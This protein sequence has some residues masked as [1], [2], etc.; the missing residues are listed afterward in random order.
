MTVMPYLQTNKFVGLKRDA[1][2]ANEYLQLYSQEI[3][4]SI[5]NK[6]EPP[7]DTVLHTTYYDHQWN[8]GEMPRRIVLDKKDSTYLHVIWMA[9]PPTDPNNERHMYYSCAISGVWTAWQIKCDPDTA[10]HRDGY[11]SLDILNTGKVIVALHRKHL[12]RSGWR[13]AVGIE[14]GDIGDGSFSFQDLD[15]TTE[16]DTPIWPKIAADSSN[17]IVVVAHSVSNDNCY[18]TVSQNLGDTWSDWKLLDT[19]GGLSY[20]CF[21][22]KNSSKLAM[23]WVHT[24]SVAV[25]TMMTPDLEVGPVMQGHVYLTISADGGTSWNS[26]IDISSKPVKKVDEFSHNMIWASWAS[27]VYGIFDKNDNVHVVWPGGLSTFSGYIFPYMGWGIWYYNSQTDSIYPVAY[28]PD[29]DETFYPYYDW[30]FYGQNAMH[31][32]IGE[33]PNTGNLYIVWAGFPTGHKHHT[34][35]RRVM[36]IFASYSLDGGRTWAPKYDITF[37]EDEA[38]GWPCLAPIVNDT[39]HIMYLWDK[40]GMNDIMEQQLDNTAEPVVYLRVPITYGDVAVESISGLPKYPD[41]V[42]LDVAYTPVVTVR[43][44][45]TSEVKCQV[46]LEIYVLP[47]DW[48]WLRNETGSR[49]TMNQPYIYK[50]QVKSETLAAGEVRDVEFDPWTY[51]LPSEPTLSLIYYKAYV[52]MLVDQDITN[53]VIKDSANAMR[54]PE[55]REDI[56]TETWW[57]LQDTLIVWEAGDDIGYGLYYGDSS[58]FYLSITYL[59]T[60]FVNLDAIWSN[61]EYLYISR[62]AINSDYEERGFSPEELVITTVDGNADTVLF[63][64]VR[65]GELLPE[66]VKYSG[67]VEL[68]IPSGAFAGTTFV[69]IDRE[70]YPVV[71]ESLGTDLQFVVNL[72]GSNTFAQPIKLVF[73]YEDNVVNEFTESSLRIFK[74]TTDTTCD[75]LPTVVDVDNNLLSCTIDEWG[76]YG[77][78][79]L[80]DT[81]PPEVSYI[82]LPSLI[83]ELPYPI[84]VTAKDGSGVPLVWLV[85]RDSLL[86]GD[87]PPVVDSIEMRQGDA[88][89]F[90]DSMPEVPDTTVPTIIFYHLVAYDAKGNKTVTS[91]EYSKYCPKL[92]LIDPADTVITE[93]SLL[94]HNDTAEYTLWVSNEGMA[95]LCVDSVAT[96]ET[97]IN[98]VSVDSSIGGLGAGKIE[99]EFID[100]DTT[101]EHHVVIT[102]Y[103]NAYNLSKANY[104]LYVTFKGIEELRPLP[105]QFEVACIPNPVISDKLKVQYAVPEPG[106]VTLKMFDLS[107]RCVK[108]LYNGQRQPGYYFTTVDAKEL[109]QGI[110]FVRLN[111]ENTSIVRKIIL[112]K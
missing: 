67:K 35:D 79:G 58:R 12:S 53:N 4:S 105:N 6:G 33:D 63:P 10:N 15:L 42:V 62:S 65:N 72:Y 90:S 9:Q 54:I 43:N 94:V 18:Y 7:R 78:M 51:S 68:D 34:T 3:G 25:D 20:N 37:T 69:A 75:T 36:D 57:D 100:P 47:K 95:E 61:E 97:W 44:L 14:Q 111:N 13:T 86:W 77:I 66:N 106:N 84:T 28:M 60:N 49:D 32:T 41:P 96:G 16:Q 87:T 91:V 59:D 110:Y 88:Y 70:L 81:I 19:V 56:T 50:Y 40:N 52:S 71:E 17:N 93:D 64:V 23:V 108:V 82:K 74:W 24:C 89:S 21:G 29:H 80:E 2:I 103:S 22:S 48:L 76:R 92:P 107:G 39:L 26:T 85:Y 27:S 102:V 8:T 99:I 1:L 109:P 55:I 11:G 46:A 73:H 112:L 31:P 101:I 98:I 45:G 30:Y 83:T 5:W 104:H 38:E